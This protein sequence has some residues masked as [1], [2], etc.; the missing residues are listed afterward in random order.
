[1]CG[2]VRFWKYKSLANTKYFARLSPTRIVHRPIIPVPKH[3]NVI[4]IGIYPAYHCTA[5]FEEAASSAE[6]K[7]KRNLQEKNRQTSPS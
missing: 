4:V 1:V 5:R 3:F 2:V 6:Y 7:E